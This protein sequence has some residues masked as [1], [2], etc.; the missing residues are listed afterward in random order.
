MKPYDLSDTATSAHGGT[1]VAETLIAPRSKGSRRSTR[2]TSTTRRSRPEFEHE[3]KCFVSPS[4][5]RLPRQTL[6]R[7]MLWRRADLLLKREDLNHTLAPTRSTTA[8]ARRFWRSASAN[9]E[10]IAETA[11]ASI[12]VAT[13][14]I[15]ARYG[16]ECVVCMGSGRQR[17]AQNVYR[18]EAAGRAA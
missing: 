8:S 13:A 5:P 7:H 18:M 14:T 11:P 17:Q 15:A 6:E 3:L 10:L 9:R 12:G 16:L 2:N 4:Q 1:F